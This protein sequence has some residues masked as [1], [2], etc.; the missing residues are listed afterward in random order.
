MTI[1][2][3]FIFTVKKRTNDLVKHYH[4]SNL[5]AVDYTVYIPIS[6]SQ[7]DA[8]DRAYKASNKEKSRGQMM[9]DLVLDHLEKS[10]KVSEGGTKHGHGSRG[11]SRV[12]LVFDNKRILKLLLDRG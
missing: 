5:Q 1:I 6:A 9:I 11:V 2:I 10:K 4:T 3:G 12:D 8:F 7:C